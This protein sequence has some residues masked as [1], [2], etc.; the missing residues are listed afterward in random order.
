MQRA[1]VLADLRDHVLAGGEGRRR[2]V[3]LLADLPAPTLSAGL[4]TPGQAM[5]HRRSLP[6]AVSR[7]ACGWWPDQ[8]RTARPPGGRHPGQGITGRPGPSEPPR[9]QE[10]P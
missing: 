1:D 2:P 10:I 3:I 4:K 9:T 8:H 7:S 6:C 5:Y